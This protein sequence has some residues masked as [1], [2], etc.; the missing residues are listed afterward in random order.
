MQEHSLSV[1]SSESSF[2]EGQELDE[3]KQ[4]HFLQRS[5]NK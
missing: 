5:A 2:H 4:L 3:K 1:L